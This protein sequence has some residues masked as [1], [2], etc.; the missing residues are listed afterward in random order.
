MDNVFR[1]ENNDVK[2]I[3]DLSRSSQLL[4]AISKKQ[5]KEVEGYATFSYAFTVTPKGRNK[6]HNDYLQFFCYDM[7]Q[8]RAFT[9][10][11]YVKEYTRTNH[12]HGIVN[13][14]QWDYKFSKMHKSPHY[15]FRFSFM[16]GG[17]GWIDYLASK[18]DGQASKP[19]Y[20][21]VEPVRR[22]IG[23]VVI[24]LCECHRILFL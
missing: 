12:I 15:V 1:E 21:Q 22:K 5:L 3:V 8:C 11:I 4:I 16:E 14:N 9:H 13:A 17:N 7:A 24:R 6:K 23:D 18:E 19:A 10:M 2:K 20:Y